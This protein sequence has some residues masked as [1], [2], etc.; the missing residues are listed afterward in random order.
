ME[1]I[2]LKCR[3]IG[4]LSKLEEWQMLTLVRDRI[5]LQVGRIDSLSICTLF[6]QASKFW[7]AIEIISLILTL[8]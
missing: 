8:P 2:L 5:E 4:E 7:Q 6:Y 3:N 1:R